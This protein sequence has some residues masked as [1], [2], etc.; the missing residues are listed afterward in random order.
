MGKNKSVEEKLSM[1]E[2]IPTCRSSGL[3]IGIFRYRLNVEVYLFQPLLRVKT[4]TVFLD[5]GD[6][7]VT[8]DFSIGVVETETL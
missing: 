1:G 5:P 2:K 8:D 3:R 4:G 6:V 7:A